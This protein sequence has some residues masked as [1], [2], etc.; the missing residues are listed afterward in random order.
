MLFCRWLVLLHHHFGKPLGECI[1]S[2]FGGM[3]L[4]IVVYHTRS[5]LWR[6]NGAFGYCMVMELGGYMV[7]YMSDSF[8]L[9]DI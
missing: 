5:H 1:S 3:I 9:S 6:I 4:G 7:P 8:K 2:Y